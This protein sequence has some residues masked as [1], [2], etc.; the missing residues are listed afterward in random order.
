M[1]FGIAFVRHLTYWLPIVSVFLWLKGSAVYHHQHYLPED[2]TAAANP[3]VTMNDVPH[4]EIPQILIQQP[5]NKMYLVLLQKR[6]LISAMPE[7]KPASRVH[8]KLRLL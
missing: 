4:Q 8:R 3:P 6:D 1:G 2:A 7:R 5:S